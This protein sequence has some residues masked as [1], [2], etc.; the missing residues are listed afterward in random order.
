MAASTVASPKLA[1]SLRTQLDADIGV[2]P[3][4]MVCALAALISLLFTGAIFGNGNHVFHLPIIHRLYDEEQFRNDVFIQSL[5][6]YSSGVWLI[7]AGS[8]KYAGDG[9]ALF[10]FLLYL[11][12]LLSFAGFLCCAQLAGLRTLRETLIFTAIL[13]FLPLLNGTSFAGQGGIFVQSFGH[14]EIAVGTALLAIYCAAR[15]R[16]AA[17]L[18]LGGATFFVN[19]FM[20]VWLAAPLIAI[21]VSLLAQRKITLA[22]LISRSLQG[23]V[24]GILLAMPVLYNVV[25]NPDFG[26]KLTFDY[27]SYLREYFGGHFFADAS[28]PHEIAFLLALVVL[29]FV[30]LS[31]LGPRTTELRAA[32]AGMV[33]LYAIGV[34][35]SLIVKSPLILNLHLLRSGL[36]IHALVA[37]AAAV[38]ATKWLNSDDGREATVLGPFLLLFLGVRYLF[39]AAII[40]AAFAD[41]LRARMQG[42]R[43]DKLRL[44]IV[45]ALILVVLPWQAWQRYQVNALLSAA[46]AEWRVVGAWARASTPVDSVFLSAIRQPPPADLPANIVRAQ[47]LA[48]GSS[49]FEAASRRRVWVDFKRGAAVMW[50][51]SYYGQWRS[52]IDDIEALGTIKQKLDYAAASGIDY[53]VEDCRASE[54]APIGPGFRTERLCVYSIAEFSA[55]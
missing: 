1:A 20:G 8:A 43:D 9:Q 21:A 13:C 35:A 25:S 27:P 32:L 48:E 36:M 31:R 6:H 33:A 37:L 2:A 54:A 34:A 14:S 17:A 46:V 55:R 45:A 19:A 10:V 40:L 3:G 51:P 52:R 49:I 50:R 22:Q 28:P 42:R 39:P 41:P 26:Q 53:V 29:G 11:S 16:F 5:R 47:A 15:G 44:V 30:V 38:L 18:L 7:L 23:G 12:R 24:G 4:V